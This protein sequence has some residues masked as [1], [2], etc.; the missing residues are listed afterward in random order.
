MV[1]RPRVVALVTLAALNVFAITAGLT[2]ADLLRARLAVLNAPRVAARPLVL[3]GPVL[4]AV[5]A[6]GP[7]PTRH[8]LTAVLSPLLAAPALGPDVGAV[9][10][11]PLSGRVLFSRGGGV[12]LTPAS[13]TKL[14][15]AVAALTVLGPEARFVTRVAPGRSPGHIVLIGGGDPTL[16]AAAPPA[17]DYPRPA[18][19]AALAAAT[20][21]AL[22]AAGIGKVRIGYDTSL[23]TGPAVPPSWDPR[24]VTTGNVT[25]VSALEVDQ[26]RLTA[27]GK[28]QDADNPANY[29][30]R[31]AHSAADAARAFAA[32]L[33]ARGIRV[34]GVPRQARAAP[35]AL[36]LATVRSPPLA[37]IVEWMLIESNNDI[38]E[39]LARHV[40]I[41][42]GRPASFSGGAAAVRAVLRRLGV[43]GG[44]H[45]VDGSGLSPDDAITPAALARLVALAASPRNPWL[46]P[47]IT[48]LPVAGF[49]GTLSASENR[50]VNKLTA[51]AIG[52]V[53]AKTG[54]LDSV[55]ALAGVV[56]DK[57]GRLITFA[58][59]INHV[60]PSM[61]T[62]SA[63]VLDRLAAAL[64]GCGCR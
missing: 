60:P 19:L 1:S 11:D 52:L 61:M 56:L 40:A 53:R 4:A 30:P 46:R 29:S 51:P 57:D 21:R 6:V 63:A 13:T 24:Y 28:P 35:G 26:G 62:A 34:T 44:V 3:A 64:A 36:P 22:A 38:A 49:S 54:T 20:A 37:Q 16:A 5:G 47:V 43:A 59:M 7:L 10:T 45:T 31:S 25:P 55:R 39:A 33:A 9:V 41:A 50:F 17:A 18:T 2:L 48:G 15:T 8:G 42:T 23:F 27:R 58:F 12:P 14:A 32:F